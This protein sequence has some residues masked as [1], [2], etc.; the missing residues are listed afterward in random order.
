MDHIKN[1]KIQMYED[2]LAGKK[3]NY[4]IELSDSAPVYLNTLN[5]IYNYAKM[6]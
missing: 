2:R 1:L 4:S 6:M 3:Q 5:T